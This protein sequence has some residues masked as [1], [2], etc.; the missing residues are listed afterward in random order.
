MRFICDEKIKPR[1]STKGSAGYDFF[2]PEDIEI[3]PKWKVT[4]D[5]GVAVELDEGYYMRLEDR[6][7]LAFNGI[8]LGNHGIIDS[9]YRNTIRVVLENNNFGDRPYVIK[10]GERYMQGIISPYMT[11]D[12]DSASAGRVG[13]IGSTGR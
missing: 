4:F 9:D 2:A 10:K 6:S 11:V 3:P 8:K 7:S 12:G 1:R 5:S 13:G